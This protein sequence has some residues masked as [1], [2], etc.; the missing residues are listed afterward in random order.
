ML[1]FLWTS[2]TLSCGLLLLLVQ[3]I[4][5]ILDRLDNV[6]VAGAATQISRNSPA[7][8]LFS[9]IWILFQQLLTSHDHARGTETALQS[10]L[11]M[12][13]FL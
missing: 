10:M 4:G 13:A 3:F 9:R 1:Q 7:N 2:C 6:R 8:F 11:L 5:G 12:E